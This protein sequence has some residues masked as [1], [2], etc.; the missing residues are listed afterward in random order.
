[1]LGGGNSPVAGEIA[2]THG[3][4]LLLDELLEFPQ[5]VREALREPMEDGCMRVTRLGRT[6]E[7]KFDA[8]II[9]T[10]NLCPCGSLTPE[11]ANLSNCSHS[12]LRCRAYLPKLSGPFVDRFDFMYFTTK[13]RPRENFVSGR[14]ILSH[15]EKVYAFLDK[16]G[17]LP[18][19]FWSGEELLASVE[20]SQRKLLLLR[21]WDSHRR[22]RATL[23]MARAF[24]DLSFSEKILSEHIHAADRMSKTNFEHLHRLA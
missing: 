13:P 4:V 19:R 20:E 24:A 16:R 12:R 11:T 5:A 6:M 15:L 23:R 8:Q 3:G 18:A 17:V 2:F 21:A 22:M 14:D 10:T 9:A 1:M 7:Y